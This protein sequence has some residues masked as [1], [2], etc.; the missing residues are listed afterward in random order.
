[1]I[2]IKYIPN[3]L[4]KDGRKETC[5]EHAQHKTIDDYICEAGYPADGMKAIVSGKVVRG[6]ARGVHDKDE[7]IITP[8]VNFD[9]GTWSAIVAVFTVIST[10]AAIAAVG[11]GIYQA[12]TY[13]KPSLPSFGNVGA[14]SGGGAMD[15]SSPTYGWEGVQTT[16]EVG[17][18]IAIVYG[19]HKIGGNVINSY[20]STDGD[21]NYLNVLLGLCEGEIDSISS[22]QINDNPIANFTGIDTYERYGTNSDSIVEGFEDLHDE[23]SVNV[24]L[25]KDNA[26]T[27]TTVGTAVEAFQILLRMPNG[28]FYTDS[29]NG[30]V[31]AWQV[32]Y[33]VEYKLHTD[34]SYT[35]LG[36]F[37]IDAKSRSV[38]R[39]Y[40]R[41]DGLTAG[42][43]DIRVTRTSDDSDFYHIGDLYWHTLD[44]IT[45][46][47]LAYPNI[48]KLGVKALASEQLS[49]SMPNITCVV[50]G[51]KVYQPK[52]MNGETEVDWED[53]YWDSTNSKWK[54]LA[55][56]TELS[57]D[58]T[59]YV[60]KW[61]ANP[62]WCLR[63]LLVNTRYGLGEYIT[64]S[65]INDADFLAL[66]KWCEEK[67]DDGDSGYEKRM[68]MDVVLD[69][70]TRAPD[71]FQQLASAFRGM[72]FYSEG[73][74]KVIADKAE[75]PV[76]LFGMGNIIEGSFSQQ[77]R[78]KKDIPNVIEVQYL[79]KD[80]NYEQEQIAYIDETALAAGDPIRKK[81]IRIFTTRTSQA[82]R[83]GRYAL[84]VNKYIDRSVSFKVAI[85]AV[86]IQAGDVINV[87]HDVPQ[88]GLSGRVQ[89]GSTTTKVKLDRSV[90]LAAG[91]TYK[92]RVK[93]TD[94]TSEE[95]TISDGA[96][97]YTEVNVSSAFSQAPAA[98][99]V[100]AVGATDAVVKP[101]RVMSLQKDAKNEIVINAV[102]YDDDIY[103]DSAITLPTDNYSALDPQLPDVTGLTLTEAVI[104]ENDGTITNAIDAWFDLPNTVDTGV[105]NLY[106]GAK[107]FLSDDNQNSWTYQ[108]YT[109]GSHFQIRGGFVVGTTYYVAVVSVGTDG[110]ANQIGD[111]AISSIAI[112]ANTQKPIDLATF[113]YT[114]DKVLE[115]NWTPVTNKDLAGYEIRD[116]DA[117]WGSSGEHLIY[118][119]LAT[120]LRLEPSA[121]TAPTYYIKAFNTSG[122]YSDAAL[123]ITPTNSAPAAPQGVAT[124]VL[125]GFG[126]L[127]WS[128]VEDNDILYYRVYQSDTGAWSGEEEAIADVS[129]LECGIQG[130]SPRNGEVTSATDSTIVCDSLIG[131]D[132]DYFNGDLI[133]IT[134]GA[135]ANEQK[136]IIDFDG[137]TGTV[138]ISGTWTT[139]PSATD[140]FVITDKS[141]YKVVAVDNYGEGT[142]SSAVSAEFQ[143]ISEE[144][145]SDQV[146]SARKIY[147]GCLSALSANMGTLT[148]GTIQGGTIQTGSGGARTVFDSQ[149]I[150][151]YDGSCCLNFEVKEGCVFAY[152][153][154]LIDP[155]CCCNYSYLDAGALKFH[156]KLG[157][158]PY[159]KRICS[160]VADTGDTIELLGWTVAPQI[161]VSTNTLQTYNSANNAQCQLAEVYSDNVTC[162]CTSA[163]CYGY[164]FDV[165]ALLRLTSGAGSE[166]AKNVAL[167][168][169]VTTAACTCETVVRL[170]FQYWCNNAAP[171]NY[172]YGTLCYKICYRVNGSETWCS[173]TYSY[174]QPHASSGEIKSSSNTCNTLAFPCMETWQI[175]VC[176]YCTLYTDSGIC[177]TTTT[178]CCV[179]C[180]AS[181][182]TQGVMEVSCAYGNCSCYQGTNILFGGAPAGT[183]YCSCVFLNIKALMSVQYLYACGYVCT[184]LTNT[185]FSYYCGSGTC[186]IQQWPCLNCDYVYIGTSYVCNMCWCEEAHGGYGAFWGHVDTNCNCISG[187][188][189][190]VCYCVLIGDAACCAYSN[191]CSLTDTYGCYCVLDPEGKLNWLAIAYS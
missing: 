177:A 122:I 181:A 49:G 41:K 112:A 187:I 85:D 64:T 166:C 37:T 129:G 161:M 67:L 70:P 32:T 92:V 66:A 142:K 106:K 178:C 10:I 24:E 186:S 20:I 118:K 170:N 88:W 15:E 149:G 107:I 91:T 78:S 175:M 44:E 105:I 21:K 103:D 34:G 90:T 68:R 29:G 36:S 55:D 123:D 87:S 58:G 150:R 42:Q 57:W 173:C 155:A 27:Y 61:C 77:W 48:A 119:G 169:C 189:Q 79:N 18:P 95:K 140:R 30:S 26:H 183:V 190:I 1:M 45:T 63:D 111:S 81:Q 174:V 143:T 8:D 137:D 100:Y 147:V 184:Y 43:Y 176:S 164:C 108:G 13:K 135:N 22:I 46:D 182:V 35:D 72:I 33:K 139:N 158:V 71:L 62:A 94:D 16:Q 101:F 11:Y 60:T 25:T 73:T 157:D 82:I 146:I 80:R 86:A 116:E 152:N 117:N 52:I 7:I 12:I 50:K 53:Y 151:S 65:N 113:T 84:L 167:G 51:K 9:P 39:R 59:T 114:F 121:R 153:L 38:V 109:E 5:V 17:L 74:L 130:N 54:L 28:L 3:I 127:R 47:D 124:D 31:N 104:T 120:K 165:H 89:T 99:D 145:L 4:S 180:T 132:D 185:G 131:F 40:F 2:I 102:E 115:M 56:D 134:S 144:M 126:K 93:F 125:F 163:T 14:N 128:N 98:Y 133:L 160:G 191:L 156:D 76:Q 19:E 83:E 75:T 154:K 188:C 159:V 141:Y 172:Y 97:T 69:S 110:R 148:S 162:F 179:T 168:E 136:T 6:F 96:G 23:K 171:S 138:T